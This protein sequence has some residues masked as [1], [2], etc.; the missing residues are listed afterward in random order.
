MYY[1]CTYCDRHYLPR[2]LALYRSLKNQCFS[3]RLWALSMDNE[4]YDAV[5]RMD[6]PEVSPISLEDFEK[7]DDELKKAKQNRTKI[8]Y[9]FT[10]SPSLPLFIL[11]NNAQVD[12]ITYLDSDIYFFSDPA[13]IYDEIADNSIAII[14][15]RFPPGFR[16]MEEFGIYNVGWLS[17]RRDE[18]GFACL[19]W[20]RARCLE[21]CHDRRENGRFADQKYL[22]NWPDIFKGVIVLGHKGAN[23][24]P[25]N[26]ANYKLQVKEG[27]V[28]VDE[29]PLIFFHFR[30]FSQVNRMTYDP[31]FAVY[32]TKL[33]LLLRYHVYKPYILTL[34]ETTRQDKSFV[35]TGSIASGI[36]GQINGTPSPHSRSSFWKRL[37]GFYNAFKG[38]VDGSF[39][40]ATNRFVI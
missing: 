8:E 34:L 4:F 28:W 24:A 2:F 3:F 32:R 33:S 14:A 22:D 35:E 20:W 10:C 7:G 5:S 15:H 23:L 9:Y 16:N 25:W 37:P 36:R 27:S 6:L 26:L 18:K 39:I 40:I 12:I 31:G 17:F 19:R 11:K 38:V 21:W 13:P 1:F 30:G 29:Q